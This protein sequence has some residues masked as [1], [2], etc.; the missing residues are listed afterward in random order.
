M[1]TAEPDR[2]ETAAS[3]AWLASSP[4]ERGHTRSGQHA[5][6]KLQP[7]CADGH[8][9][10]LG[11]HHVLSP[12]P[13]VWADIPHTPHACGHQHMM[14]GTSAHTPAIM[15]SA[16][17]HRGARPPPIAH[18]PGRRLRARSPGRLRARPRPPPSC[19]SERCAGLTRTPPRGHPA[20][21]A[22]SSSGDPRV[23]QA[24]RPPS[25][26]GGGVRGPAPGAESES[27]TRAFGSGR[28]GVRSSSRRS[29]ARPAAS[30][31]AAWERALTRTPGRRGPAGPPATL[32]LSRHPRLSLSLF[33]GPAGPPA[34]RGP[35]PAHREPQSG[36][37]CRSAAP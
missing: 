27:R 24:S 30:C 26:P 28:A 10:V 31:S 1:L 18:A 20:R 4:G 35:A 22:R 8:T 5:P 2:Q 25:R 19:M 34:T 3:T 12:L 23:P 7:S 6:A 36:C 32:S 9:R 29:A 15:R 11:S 17:S 14:P 16:P 33:R 13:H 21:T 37:A